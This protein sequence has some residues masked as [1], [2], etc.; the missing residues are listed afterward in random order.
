MSLAE[1]DT[2]TVE[3]RSPVLQAVAG[4]LFRRGRSIGC[5]GWR[6]LGSLTLIP[7]AGMF[8]LIPVARVFILIAGVLVLTITG[9]QPPRGLG[10]SLGVGHRSEA[11]DT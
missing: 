2:E 6:I 8:P 7:V 4:V 9:G 1:C 3:P 5:P 10:P 11:D